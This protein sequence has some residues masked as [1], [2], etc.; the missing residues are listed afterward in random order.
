MLRAAHGA[1][2][3]DRHDLAHDQP[4]E[5]H[6]DAGEMLLDGGRRN[7]LQQLLDVGGDVDGLDVAQMGDAAGLAPG[8]EF[9]GR[10]P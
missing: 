10:L 1:G 6:P 2:R 5:Q 7:P 9:S 4:V 8:G 3:I